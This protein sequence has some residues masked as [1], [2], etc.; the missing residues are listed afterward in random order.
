MQIQWSNEHQCNLM[1]SFV[2]GGSM[3]VKPISSG[4]LALAMFSVL[5]TTLFQL[6]L[7]DA[8]SIRS[9]R[10]AAPSGFTGEREVCGG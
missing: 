6:S 7:E 3:G 10:V 4:G 5:A 2:S 1:S 9:V 8:L